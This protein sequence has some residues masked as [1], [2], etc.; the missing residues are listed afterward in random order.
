MLGTVKSSTEIFYLFSHGKRYATPALTLIVYKGKTQHGPSGRVAFVAG[1]KQG[2]AVWRNFAKRRM[3]ALCRDLGGPWPDLIVLF[4][5]NRK[6]TQV[7]YNKMLSACRKVIDS[8]KTR[9][10]SDEKSLVFHQSYSSA[11]SYCID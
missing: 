2:N 1:K 8:C 5:A 10:D 3:R 4:V 6:T 7:R 11:D 9:A